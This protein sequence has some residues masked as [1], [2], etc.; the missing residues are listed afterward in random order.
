MGT[1][2][3][4]GGEPNIG[5]AGWTLDSNFSLGSATNGELSVGGVSGGVG[6]EYCT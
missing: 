2:A 4:R 5:N 6:T 3:G 1:P